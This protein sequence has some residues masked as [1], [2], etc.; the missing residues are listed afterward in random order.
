MGA[1]ISTLKS[2]RRVE[3]LRG[4]LLVISWTLILHV[5]CFKEAPHRRNIQRS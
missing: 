3:R 4:D 1:L 5:R 2:S